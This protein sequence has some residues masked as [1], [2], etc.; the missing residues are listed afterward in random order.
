M[1]GLVLKRSSK[2][3]AKFSF[4]IPADPLF[5]SLWCISQIFDDDDAA[6]AEEARTAL[7]L[8]TF[9]VS[10]AKDEGLDKQTGASIEGAE[11][12]LHLNKYEYLMF[13]W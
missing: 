7:V 1:L 13:D 5:H 8:N 9:V 6:A 4:L 12:F 10:K 3:K 2:V 11:V